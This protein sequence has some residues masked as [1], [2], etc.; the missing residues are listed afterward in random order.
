MDKNELEKSRLKQRKT[1]RRKAAGRKKPPPQPEKPKLSKRIGEMGDRKKF[2]RKLT[3]PEPKKPALNIKFIDYPSYKESRADTSTPMKKQR[4]TDM[5]DALQQK[6]PTVLLDKSMKQ[7][8]KTGGKV[9]LALK[10][11]GR[12]YGRNS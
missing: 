2:G 1:G 11:G 5:D 3:V 7:N 4:L 12:A 10:G 8:Y 6:G 9:K